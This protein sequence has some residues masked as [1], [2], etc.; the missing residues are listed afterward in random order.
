MLIGTVIVT[1][2]VLLAFLDSLKVLMIPN[3][4][5]MWGLVVFVLL[6][7]VGFLFGWKGKHVAGIG[8][9]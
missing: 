1:I 3:L 5:M 7:I 8:D 4:T 9:V 2:A 6:A